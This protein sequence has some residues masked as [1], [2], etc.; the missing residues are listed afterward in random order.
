MSIPDMPQ[1][2]VKVLLVAEHASARFGG[3]AALSLHYFRVL[4][5]RGVPTWL[6]VHERTR[7]ELA[8]L[9][10]LDAD[11][12]VY[13]SDNKWHRF[14]WRLGKPLPSGLASF[15]T[16]FAIRL[17]T[18]I[19]QR[20]IVRQLVKRHGI[21]VVHQPM[22][23]SPKEPSLIYNVGAP[24]IIGPMNGGMNY[25]PAFRRMQGVIEEIS[26]GLGR[27]VAS[28]MN[29]IIPGKRKAALL[30]VA[31]QRTRMAL[32]RGISAEVEMLVENGVDL[33]LWKA[34]VLQ[35]NKPENPVTRLVFM[36]RLIALKG[37]DHLLEA[38][39]RVA[40]EHSISLSI[41]GDDV[42][43][44]NLEKLAS[45]LGILSQEESPSSG[46]VKF[47]GWL[48]QAACAEVLANADVLVLPSLRE[49][50]GAVV[51]EAMAMG[52]PVIATDWGGPA[53]YLDSS[54]GI[55]VFPESKEV[56]VERLSNA[57]S[58]MAK[59]PEERKAMGLAARAKVVGEFDWEVKVDR[60]MQ[61]Y[62]RVI[63]TRSHYA[64]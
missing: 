45:D 59:Y 25:P 39:A 36:G 58:R 21:D 63:V 13:V 33:H 42:A 49:C 46:K 34:P 28:L 37:V 53:D 29:A 61:I 62:R 12:I 20:R 55:L 54:C 8:S 41:I 31:N 7:N 32:P 40:P 19:E 18:Q 38:F 47:F 30:L 23:V 27:G 24:V 44:L 64:E 2:D 57:I 15:T 60:M 1:A 3:E 6:V 50:G 11:R 10:P 48:A 26:L 9:F 17:I 56:F 5:A 14:F 16:A 43:R 51:L 35:A 22:P 52:V 4:R